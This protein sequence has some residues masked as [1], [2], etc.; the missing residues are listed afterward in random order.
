MTFE[1]NLLATAILLFTL[2]GLA[3][4]THYTMTICRRMDNQ[5]RVA[6]VNLAFWVG[7]LIVGLAFGWP[8]MS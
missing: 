7:V 6:F 4:V 1:Q 5:R 8:R 2:C 3:S